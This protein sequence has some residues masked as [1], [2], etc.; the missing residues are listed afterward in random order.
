ME[1]KRR[2]PILVAVLTFFA[3]FIGGVVLSLIVLGATG[4][5]DDDSE[6][7]GE[8]VGEALMP[9]AMVAAAIAYFVQDHRRRRG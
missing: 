7:R 8:A 5:L 2:S 4:K 9:G 1:R 3:V 6:A